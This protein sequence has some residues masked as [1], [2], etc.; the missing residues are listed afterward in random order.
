[1]TEK[2]LEAKNITLVKGKQT[3][4]NIEHF[5][6]QAG[7]TLALIG[8][9]GSGKSTL[10]QVLMMLLRP[11]TGELFFNGEKI[12]WKNA[13]LYRRRMAMVF[14][15]PLLLDTTV[16]ENIATGLKIRGYEKPAI[17]SRVEEWLKKLG[18]EH[19]AGRTSRYLSGGEAQRVSLARAMAMGPEVLFLDE[20]FS[21]LDAPTRT[22]LIAELSGIL[23]DSRISSV[24]VTH[25]YTEIPL[26]AGRVVALENGRVVQTG[27]PRE[28]LTRPAS[29]TVAS[30]VGVE[31]VIPGRLAGREGEKAAVQAGPHLIMAAGAKVRGGK[32]LILIR[33]EAVKLEGCAGGSG[34]NRIN[35]RIARLLPHGGLFK[36]VV[37]CGFPLTMIL[38]P[39][40]VFGGVAAPGEEVTVCFDPGKVHLLDEPS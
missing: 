21:A 40:Q 1:M 14:Q 20:P 10:M 39:E 25:D 36:A 2:I 24:L 15:E 3:I 7:E 26:L 17:R 11:T 33:P 27:P 28:I 6:L 29:L 37:D 12:N 38:S 34:G 32:V 8:P 4:L 22:G 13:I 18:I 31:N 30:L 19:L 9:N 35:G 23:Q 16:A 5:Y